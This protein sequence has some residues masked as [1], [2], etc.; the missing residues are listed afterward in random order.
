M[1]LIQIDHVVYERK[2]GGGFGL[3][4][5]LAEIRGVKHA[6]I[7]RLDGTLV[8]SNAGS[9][10]DFVHEPSG[11]VIR[12]RLAREARLEFERQQMRRVV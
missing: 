2:G 3:V 4:E 7:L 12:R 11:R 8:A 1:Y 5:A 9:I 6:H 10:Y